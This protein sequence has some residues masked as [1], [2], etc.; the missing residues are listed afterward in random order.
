MPMLQ[1]GHAAM[2]VSAATT[3]Y[4]SLT[5]SR[6]CQS[7]DCRRRAT[8]GTPAVVVFLLSELLE[9]LFLPFPFPF[10]FPFPLPLP[11][12]PLLGLGTGGGGAA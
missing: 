6:W 11:L 10:P 1:A 7:R 4:A 12:P 9:P 3:N 2:D 8:S 5:T